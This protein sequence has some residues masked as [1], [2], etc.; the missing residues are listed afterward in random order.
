LP[1]WGVTIVPPEDDGLGPRLAGTDRLLA[2]VAAYR[3]RSA[4]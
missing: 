1:T 2:S 3:P 4:G